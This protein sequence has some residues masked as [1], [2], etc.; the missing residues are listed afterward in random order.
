MKTLIF[1]DFQGPTI[2]FHDFPGLENEIL[3]FH[4]F[5]GFPWLIRALNIIMLKKI[6]CIIRKLNYTVLSALITIRISR[7][8][9]FN[10]LAN[11]FLLVVDI[12]IIIIYLI[13]YYHFLHNQHMLFKAKLILLRGF[14][15]T[16]LKMVK[17][18]T[19]FILSVYSKRTLYHPQTIASHFV[20]SR[21]I[22]DFQ[23]LPTRNNVISQ[24][25]R[26]CTFPAHSNRTSRLELF[27][28][29]TSLHF[30]IHL[31]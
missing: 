1:H 20:F 29:P 3:K 27:A 17:T 2:T 18:K 19:T 26:K 5:P 15:W 9:Y 11:C 12:V 7:Y 6:H 31:S 4:D 16:K 8:S 22:L 10:N 13:F 30:W 28:P 24:I 14:L 23:G 21:I 25:V